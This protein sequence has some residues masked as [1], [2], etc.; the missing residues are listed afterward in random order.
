M[1]SR[2]TLA[3]PAPGLGVSS[4][5]IQLEPSDPRWRA[6]VDSHP[7][8][9]AFH[10]PAWSE[11]LA[12]CYGYRPIV[13]ARLGVNGAVIGGLPVMEVR[14]L[15]RQRR[16]VALP[17]SDVCA[18]LLGP[19]L[20]LDEFTRSLDD[21]RRSA[22]VSLF[23]VRAPLAE[24]A[25]AHRQNTAVIHTVT[26][27]TDP[28][29]LFARLHRSQVQRNVRRGEREQ[30]FTIRRSDNPR[31]LTHA[32]YSLHVKTRQRHGMPVQPRRY[33]EAMWTHVLGPGDGHVLIAESDGEPVAAIVFVNGTSTLT[34]KYSASDSA[35]WQF[36][37]N[38]L[39]LWHSMQAAI[40][41]GYRW[42]DFGRSDLADQGL[43]DFKSGWAGEEQ[44]LVYTTLSE[45]PPEIGSGRGLAV[46]RKVLRH[47]PGWACRATGELFYRYGA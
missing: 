45:R 28:V 27:G 23:D 37:P 20:G 7:K 5:A 31:D 1:S 34:Y 41:D 40:R 38:H 21:A 39:L 25:N 44:P 35:F 24:G 16:W 19:D 36:R 43:R 9:L 26:L 6:F 14:T 18:P 10:R 13:L 11:M 4:A 46:A 12:D 22:G 29:A 33:F 3:E 17:F 42:F 2:H 8:A 32:F 30:R 47:S 15:R